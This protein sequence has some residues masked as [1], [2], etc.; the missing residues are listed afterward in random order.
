MRGHKVVSP[1]LHNAAS[2]PGHAGRQRPVGRRLPQTPAALRGAGDCRPHAWHRPGP[3]NG[4]DG[5]GRRAAASAGAEQRGPAAPPPAPSPPAVPRS[6]EGPR[7]PARSRRRGPSGASPRGQ[8]PAP[9]GSGGCRRPLPAASRPRSPARGSPSRRPPRS[10]PGQRW[11]RQQRPSALGTAHALPAA[12]PPGVPAMPPPPRSTSR[13]P[14]RSGQPLLR[15][16]P[17]HRQPRRVLRRR[18]REG[19]AYRSVCS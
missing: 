4:G 11:R 3:R 14:T 6:R 13:R 12:A 9:G 7:P 19:G 2:S 1:V 17:S 15:P 5:E 10:A 8:A 18:G 16:E